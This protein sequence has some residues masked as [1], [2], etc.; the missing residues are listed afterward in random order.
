MG[1]AANRAPI[2]P[3]HEGPNGQYIGR[4]R[5]FNEGAHQLMPLAAFVTLTD[6]TEWKKKGLIQKTVRP[7]SVLNEEIWT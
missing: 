5:G 6:F 2:Y 4:A 1:G 7:S 3:R